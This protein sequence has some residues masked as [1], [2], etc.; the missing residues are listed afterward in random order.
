MYVWSAHIAAWWRL[1]TKR[2]FLEEQQILLIIK[3]SL[4]PLS[5]KNLMLSSIINDLGSDPDRN[6]AHILVREKSG[7]RYIIGYLNFPH[8][9]VLKTWLLACGL[10]ATIMRGLEEGSE[11]T[12]DVSLT[13]TWRPWPLL[14]LCFIL[15][16]VLQHGFP[17]LLLRLCLSTWLT[18]MVLSDKTFETVS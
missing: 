8:I 11:V 16:A 12:R 13:G 9:H 7:R 2:R 4:Q 15:A 10:L 14:L 6:E 3:P 1:E 5:L 18:A 17:D